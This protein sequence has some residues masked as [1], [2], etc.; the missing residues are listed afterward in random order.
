MTLKILHDYIAHEHNHTARFFHVFKKN[1]QIS[2]VRAE[3]PEDVK[4]KTPTITTPISL[5][6]FKQK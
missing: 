3:G 4:M 1:A 5:V 2:A 6:S